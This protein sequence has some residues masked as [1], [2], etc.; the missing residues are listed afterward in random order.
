MRPSCGIAIEDAYSL[1]RQCQH[2][3]VV[4]TSTNLERDCPKVG[5]GQLSHSRARVV[6]TSVLLPHCAADDELA[7]RQH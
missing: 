1:D 6:R 7:A 3:N 2:D 4:A 5:H